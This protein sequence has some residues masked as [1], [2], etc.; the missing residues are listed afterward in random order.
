MYISLEKKV[1][2]K[3]GNEGVALNNKGYLE[4]MGDT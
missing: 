3:K 2:D 1:H 4:L